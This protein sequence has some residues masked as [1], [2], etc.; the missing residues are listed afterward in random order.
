MNT[1]NKRNLRTD[2]PVPRS[3]PSLGR[4]NPAESRDS[5]VAQAIHALRLKAGLTQKE[6]AELV[7]TS[8]SVISRLEDSKYAGHSVAMLRRVGTAL[9][10]EV[11]IRFVSSHSCVETA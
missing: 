8:A 9:K 1:T 4:D 2:K 7:G 5:G 3:E 6:L 11:Q 10:R